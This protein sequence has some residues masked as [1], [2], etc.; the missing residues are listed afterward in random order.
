MKKMKVKSIFLRKNLHIS[1]SFD[2]FAP[3]N[4]QKHAIFDP[5]NGQT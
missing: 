1:V 3:R 5:H 2:N 4:G